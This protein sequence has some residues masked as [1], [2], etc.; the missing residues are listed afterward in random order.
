MQRCNLVRLCSLQ[1]L[2]EVA[3]MLVGTETH[4]YSQL[5]VPDAEFVR[6]RMVIEKA[7]VSGGY[8]L[9]LGITAA[10]G[11]HQTPL[12]GPDSSDYLLTLKRISDFNVV[13]Y[14]TGS[15]RAWLVDGASALLHLTC[16]QLRSANVVESLNLLTTDLARYATSEQTPYAVLRN[17]E[18]R[19]HVIR[20]ETQ[21]NTHDGS[22]SVA[23]ATS[24][25]GI[26]RFADLVASNCNY[27]LKMQ[28]HQDKPPSGVDVRLTD[29]DRVE[30]WSFWDVVE[31]VQFLKPRM[32]YLQPSGRGWT[33]YT[34]A[35][36]AITL[37]GDG[38]GELIARSDTANTCDRWKKVPEGRDYLVTTIDRLRKN[39][40]RHG[41]IK[42]FPSFIADGV[43]WHQPHEVFGECRCPSQKC[44]PVQV[45]LPKL[46][47]H[48]K[49]PTIPPGVSD[50]GAVIFGQSEK[51]RLWFPKDSS[52]APQID[53]RGEMADVEAREENE[54]I[55]HAN[56]MQEPQAQSSSSTSQ[57]DPNQGHP[58]PMPTTSASSTTP[59]TSFA[60]QE[61]SSSDTGN[62]NIAELSEAQLRPVE[63]V[64]E[65]SQVRN[66]GSTARQGFSRFTKRFRQTDRN[67]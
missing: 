17:R 20:K 43:R 30:G 54:R 45:I 6:A 44:D 15:K 62:R 19:E 33:E 66:P 40:R 25:E 34:R 58:S 36:Q 49:E 8:F 12:K 21:S 10:R 60:S 51:F 65:S 2:V 11:Q 16:T 35:V 18:T 38:F 13:L 27:M 67:K 63:Q 14:D 47:W 29:R 9:N 56:R 57:D 61:E 5:D 28:E 24:D 48:N 59:A 37:M 41:R 22:G 64:A 7:T 53:V 3:D 55:V 26:W 23:A 52:Q 1:L 39:G 31:Q 42:D 32:T 50:S 4:D 46:S